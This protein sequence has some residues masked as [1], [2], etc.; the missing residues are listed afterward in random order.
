MKNR[1]IHEI[2]WES[3]LFENDLNTGV[4]MIRVNNTV[5]TEIEAHPGTWLEDYKQIVIEDHF[6]HRQGKFQDNIWSQ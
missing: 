4:P 1:P 2:K 5:F 6:S 3:S